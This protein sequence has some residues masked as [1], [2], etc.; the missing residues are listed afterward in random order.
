MLSSSG[1]EVTVKFFLDWVKEWNP[2]IKPAIIMTDGDQVQINAIKAIYSDSTILLCWW[3]VLHTMQTHFCTEEFPKLWEHIHKWIKTP[4]PSKFESW[5]EEMQTD[6]L[7][8][9]SFIDYLRENWMPI[10]PM[11]SGSVQKNHTIFQEGDMNMLIESQ[12]SLSHQK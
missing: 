9:L 10:M 6:P 3:H 12:L 2:E 7:V 5:W 8:P 4:D 1:T 11:W